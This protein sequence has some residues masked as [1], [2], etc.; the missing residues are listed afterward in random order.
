[1]PLKSE[2]EEISQA[3]WLIRLVWCTKCQSPLR[4][5]AFKPNKNDVDGL[6]LFREECLPG[7]EFVLQAVREH[8]RDFYGIWK[9]PLSDFHKAGLIL[10]PT[11]AQVPGHVSVTNLTPAD[12]EKDRDSLKAKL[13]QLA[14]SANSV[15]IRDPVR[16]NYKPF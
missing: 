4:S 6:S 9:W 12:W 1:L 11:K 2:E 8:T 16:R 5:E 15:K 13:E 7:P 14:C 10:K 3:E